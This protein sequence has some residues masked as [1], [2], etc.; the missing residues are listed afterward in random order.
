MLPPTGL[1]WGHVAADGTVDR[2]EWSYSQ[3]SPIAAYLLLYQTT[4][5]RSALAR[6]EQ[7]A[8]G[9]LS[10]FSGRWLSEPPEFA[11]IF[12]QHV[13]EL[14][15]VDGRTQYVAPTQ[16]YGGGRSAARRVPRA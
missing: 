11:A 3:G 4:G 13:L 1:Y 15:A 5:D 10:A 2:R 7:L 9:T 6:A 16:A 8:D 14:A 12:F